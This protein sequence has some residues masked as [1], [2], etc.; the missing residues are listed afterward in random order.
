MN[1]ISNLQSR[2]DDKVKGEIP[3]VSIRTRKRR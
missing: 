2:Q 3:E 1:L